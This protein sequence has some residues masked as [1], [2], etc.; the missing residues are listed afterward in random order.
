MPNAAD[1]GTRESAFWQFSLAFYA[2]PGVPA[3]CLEL[4]DSA[5]VDVNVLLYLLFLANH[6]RQLVDADVAR[7]D[8]LI[9]EWRELA[10][11]PLRTLRRKLK[12]GIAPM[13]SADT[14]ALRSAIKRI[15]L[16]AERVEQEWLERY[17]PPSSL[18]APAPSRVAAARANLA[19][20]GTLRNGLPDS[21]VEI[22]LVAYG[23]HVD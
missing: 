9:H 10:V 4:Q 8:V 20:Y 5:G 11:I 23:E 17:A 13:P 16:D 22:L 6:Q 1:A 21:A 14:E 3:A 18:G 2:R 15:E 7:I 12:T 19:A